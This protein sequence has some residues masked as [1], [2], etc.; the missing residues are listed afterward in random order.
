MKTFLD[1]LKQKVIVFDGAM[2]TNIQAQ[3]LAADDF[4]GEQYSGCNENLVLTRPS[5]IEKIHADVLGAG[6]DVVETDTFGGTA[7]V[8][9][10]YGLAEK[11]YELNR[12][13]A[14]LACRVAREFSTPS[15]PRFVAGSMGPTTKLPSL[16][17]ISFRDMEAAYAVQARGLIDG[18]VDLLVVETCQ[19]LLQ[20]KAALAGVFSAFGELGKRVPVIA[21][22]TI[23]TMGTMLLGT[24]M[25]AALAALEAFDV[26][27]IGMNCATGPKEMSENVRY[28]CA[29]SPRPVFMMP[30]AGLP[31]NIGGHAHY[32]LTPEE[33]VHYL[34][35]FVKD[36]GVSI[37]GGCCGTTPDHLRKLVEAVGSLSPRARTVQFMPGCSS[38]YGYAPFH[39]EPAP[40][41]I[42]ER[43]NANGSKQFR[44][45]LAA[46]NWEGMVGMG[47]AQVKEGAHIL[48]VCVAY[49]GRDEARDMRELISRFNTQITAP[50]MIDSTEPP[51]IEEALQRIAGKAIVNSINM[52]DGE[53]R[54]ARVLPLC[55][56]YGAAVIAL[57]IDEQGMAK[58]VERKVDIA[59]RIH[60]LATRKY[61]IAESDLIFDTLT[62]TLGSGDEEFRKSGIQ[63]IEAISAIKKEFPRV[64]TSLGVSNVSFGLSAHARHVLNSVFLHYAIEQGLDMAIVHASK[65]LPLYKI[66]EKERE[67]SRKLIFDERAP[68]Y[69]PLQELLAFYAAAKGEAKRTTAKAATIE[70]RL[71]NRIIDGD[72]LNL[73]ADLDEGLKKYAALDIINNILLDGMK[74]VGDLFGSGQMQLPFVLQSAEVMKSAVAYLE[75]YMDKAASASKGTMV[76]ATVKGDVHDIGKN[77]VDIIL[78]NNGYKV[79]NL[80]I[81]C[82]LD[83]MLGAYEEHGADAIGMSGLLVKST[84]IMKENLEVMNERSLLPPVILGGAALTRRYV[85]EDLRSVYP[86]ELAYANDAFDGLRF[87]E[88]IARRKQEGAV[89]RPMANT[90]AGILGDMA[91]A[92]EETLALLAKVPE[93]RMT[94]AGAS[95]P[96]S[97]HDVVAHLAAWEGVCA[98]RLELYRAGK[99]EGIR[100]IDGEELRETN[101]RFVRERSSRPYAE[102]A[103]EWNANRQRIVSALGG[104]TDA[105]LAARAGGVSIY[106]M[107]AENTFRHQRHHSGVLRRW[108]HAGGSDGGEILSGLEA[109][110]AMAPKAAAAFSGAKGVA[111]ADVPTAPFWGSKVVSE[112]SLDEVFQ[113][114]NEVA[115]IRGQWQVRRG[116]LSEADYARL[117]EQ[118]VYPELRE[119]KRESIERNLLTPSV[120]YG[121][122]PCQAVGDDLVVYRPRDDSDPTSVWSTELHAALRDAR[123]DGGADRASGLLREWVRFRF[124]RQTGGRQLCIADFFRSQDSGRLDVVAFHLVTMGGVASRHAHELFQANN[125]KEYL[126]FHGLSVESAEALAELWHKRIREE[127][128]IAGDDAPEIRK[129]FSQKY[130]GSRYSFGYPAC[131]NLEDQQKLFVLLRPDRIGVQLSEEFQLHPEQSTS[132]IV[133]HHPQARYFNIA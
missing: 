104:M 54:M 121:Y 24:E 69:D 50:L 85:E 42:G 87:M 44:E 106:E 117:L 21:S 52:E 93:E 122:Y 101:A 79:V 76:I 113:Y 1:I 49:V 26:D 19:D 41:L 55:K 90:I 67:L 20:A 45:F 57:T 89:P 39:I 11:A 115:L 59:R 131:P 94:E 5:A 60:A 63:T 126:Y 108:L 74:V 119:L 99:G 36:L 127:L 110:I 14:K 25:A 33:F 47:K 61:G 16:G 66:S 116:K 91:E 18:G 68:G 107:V 103:A 9:S 125:Y 23:E 92:F 109:K 123:S 51:V 53:E 132:A 77:L 40:V 62:F 129:L 130:R 15:H 35:H 8:L 100:M 120:V 84:L 124:P 86:G 7:I 78:T 31:E 65:I 118:K 81:Q 43:T 28:L 112:I 38:L 27:I 46:E 34:S 102:I 96:W 22:V 72:K 105:D 88:A 83:R 37:V 80:G 70:E 73:Q 17:H 56:K 75:K 48:D 2:G 98:D 133:V 13:A 30:N 3:N 12:E 114:I 95:G 29:N 97:V 6:C 71:K 58:T 128:G 4:G 111:P 82:P 64:H 10:E 32:R